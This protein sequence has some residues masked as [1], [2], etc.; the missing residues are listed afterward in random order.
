MTP[1]NLSILRAKLLKATHI[2]GR[3]YGAYLTPQEQAHVD[4]VLGCR[5]AKAYQT[6]YYFMVPQG[7]SN[8]DIV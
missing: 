1:K 6:W 8:K 5:H 2:L 4:K 7:K 3:S